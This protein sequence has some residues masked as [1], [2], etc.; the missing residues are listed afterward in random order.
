MRKEGSLTVD[1]DK[2]F[3]KKCTAKATIHFSKCTP[4][5][6]T[7]ASLK[8][9]TL[10]ISRKNLSR[11]FSF[12]FLHKKRVFRFR[13]MGVVLEDRAKA[14]EKV[15]VCFELAKSAFKHIFFL[16]DSDQ[17]FSVEPPFCCILHR[18]GYVSH[19]CHCSA[20]LL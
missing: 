3:Q 17:F 16:L 20:V 9:T 4:T 7:Q 14:S 1:I 13:K 11:I 18:L 15:K 2:V 19:L 8:T 10:R 12:V 6:S 5:A